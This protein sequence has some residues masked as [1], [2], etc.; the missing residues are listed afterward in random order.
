[1]KLSIIT[2]LGPNETISQELKNSLLQFMIEAAA[3]DLVEWVLV[4]GHPE[5]LERN[6]SQIEGVSK[7]LPVRKIIGGASRA[8]CMNLGAKQSAGEILWFLHADSS[9]S[10]E[11]AKA[12]LIKTDY[13]QKIYYFQLKFREGPKAMRINEWGVRFRCHFLKTPFGDQG[14]SMSKRTFE[15]LGTYD[16]ATPYGEDH[17]LI[18]K[19][20]EMKIEILPV[21]ESLFTSPR[22]YQE[23]GWLKTTLTHQYMWYKQI[24]SQHLKKE[25]K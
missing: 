8:T 7:A 14:L 1:M 5:M 3:T 19:A 22:K 23:K 21:G 18:R 24:L 12:F 4:S 11:A 10:C 17:L 16:E 15:T 2:S 9:F 13:D 6:Y 20:R 25:P